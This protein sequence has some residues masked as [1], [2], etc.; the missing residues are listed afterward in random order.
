MSWRGTLLLVLIAGLALLLFLLSGQSLTRSAQEPLLVIAPLQADRIDIGESGGTVTLARTN[1]IWSITGD[2]ADR[3]DP[4]MVRSLLQA[5]ADLVPSDQIKAGNLGSGGGKLTL[6]SLGLKKTNRSLS[7]RSGKTQL[8]RFGIEGAAKGRLYA[9]LDS[10]GTVYLIPGEIAALAFHPAQD[11]RD[12]RLTALSADRLSGISFS[13]Q[14]AIHA[15][16]LKKDSAGWKLGSP[17]EAEADEEALAA[18]IRPVLDAPVESWMPEGTD[19]GSCGLDAPT[20]LFTLRCDGAVVPVTIS[21]GSPVPGMADTFHVRCSDRPGICRV[22][23]IGPSLVITPTALRSRRL[24]PVQYDAVDRIEFEA[25]TGLVVLVRKPAGQDWMNTDGTPV[26][27]ERVRAW[28]DSMQQLTAHGFEPATPAK[29]QSRGLDHPLRIR[30]IAQLSEN[31]AEEKAG[32]MILGDYAIGT[33]VLGETALREG[34]SSDFLILPSEPLEVLKSISPPPAS[35]P[36]TDP[37]SH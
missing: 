30:L 1:G 6:E 18:W 26:P 12:H 14:G 17:V 13:R 31:T 29:L 5:A 33:S 25:E 2:P 3:A 21:V 20:A 9:R 4:R 16:E 8:L 32:T 35:S 24:H 23:G 27:G 11:F 19:P 22:R 34:A 15:I 10:D 37:A 7:I 28:F 36:G